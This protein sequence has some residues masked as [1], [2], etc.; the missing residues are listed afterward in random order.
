M[1]SSRSFS[2]PPN[3]G[4]SSDHTYTDEQVATRLAK[5][6]NLSDV[7]DAAASRTNLGLGNSATRAVGTTTGTVAAG[8]DSRIVGAAQKT[9]N[10][11]DL[12]SASTARTN[13]GLGGAALLNVGT[14]TGTVAA[15]DDSRITGAAQKSANLSDLSN[16]GTARTNLGLG[17]AALLSVGTA[18]GT[19][20]AGDDSRI[21]G[22]AQK[23]ANLSDLANASTARTNLGL[24]GAATLSVGTA[25]GTVAAG[26]DV[27]F[28]DATPG[29]HGFITWSHDPSLTVT[30]QAPT[31]GSIYLVGVFI[32][33]TQ[34]ATKI[35]FANGAAATSI[36]AGQS[37]VGIYNSAGTLQASAGID[38]QIQAS[39]NAQSATISSTS[40]TPAMYWIAILV[41]YS[42]GLTLMRGSNGGHTNANLAT[43]SLRFA[44]NGTT[45]TSLPS[46]ITPASNTKG[47][48]LPWWV[49]LS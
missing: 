26:D 32:R 43:A 14:A 36:T 30:S 23:S 28:S 31:A 21:T 39:A 29:D 16:A 20:A 8:D 38:T 22:A 24:G 27:R 12:G 48:S 17:G 15:G 42:G 3:S 41:N 37:F 4:G 7:A 6:A 5:A 25:T 19:V 2:V 11:S 35:W 1:S 9:A 18:T 34:S 46:S 10:L 45:Q 47:G 33:R 40:L 49:A 44:I 13:L